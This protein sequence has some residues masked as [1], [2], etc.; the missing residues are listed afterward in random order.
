MSIEMIKIIP[1]FT[2]EIDDCKF[3]KGIETTCRAGMVKLLQNGKDNHGNSVYPLKVVQ[4]KKQ[5]KLETKTI[6]ED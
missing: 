5:T 3:I 6:K 4:E 2:A 1:D